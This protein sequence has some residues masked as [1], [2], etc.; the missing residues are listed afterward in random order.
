MKMARYFRKTWSR[1]YPQ[2]KKL[3]YTLSVP[4]L[5]YLDIAELDEESVKDGMDV[6]V[7]RSSAL[8][9]NMA[10]VGISRDFLKKYEGTYKDLKILATKID[11]GFGR[12]LKNIVKLFGA[13]AVDVETAQEGFFRYIVTSEINLSLIKEDIEYIRSTKLKHYRVQ[14]S[15]L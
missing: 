9:H 10:V 8:L 11:T 7:V 6:F 13:D 12:S 2:R 14:V 15:E 4:N 3:Q 1:W 5:R